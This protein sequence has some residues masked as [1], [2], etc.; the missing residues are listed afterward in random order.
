[1]ATTYTIRVHAI[2][3]SDADGGRACTVTPERFAQAIEGVNG[4]FAP[5]HVRFAFD[6]QKDWHP[7]RDTSLNN[8]HNGGVKWWVEANEVAAKHRGEFTVFLRHGKHKGDPSEPARNWFAY[9]PNTGQRQ[10][11]RAKL[12]HDNIDFIAV[13]NQ[14][15]RFGSSGIVLAHEVGHFLGL[16]HTHPG[17]RT[18]DPDEMIALVESEGAAA[19]NGDLLSDTPPIR[20][21]PTTRSTYTPIPAPGRAASGSRV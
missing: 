6:P 12:P 15:N 14:Q 18:P 19:L 20:A 5:A 11:D 9:P 1:M 13:T 21:R 3:L 10:P 4:I 7:R 16:F 8:L 2:A 17:W